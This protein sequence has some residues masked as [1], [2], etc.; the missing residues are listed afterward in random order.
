MRNRQY[1]AS[2]PVGASPIIYPDP[3]PAANG[4]DIPVMDAHFT[5]SFISL[6]FYDD[7]GGTISEDNL[8]VPANLVTPGAGTAT[9]TASENGV[10]YGTITNGTDIDVTTDD[11]PRIN[12]LGSVGFI[13]GVTAGITIATH[14]RILTTRS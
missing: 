13:K 8:Y 6:E 1:I 9:V 14:W 11:Y 4:K 3:N 7:Q 2:G 10:A 12:F 5:E